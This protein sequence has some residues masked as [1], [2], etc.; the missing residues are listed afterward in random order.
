MA[1]KL[2]FEGQHDDEE[3]LFTF[4]RHPI[5]MRKGF[6]ALLIPFVLGSIPTL[7]WPDNLQNLWIAFGGLGLGFVLFLYHWMG[8]YFSIFIIT[9]QRLRQI[10]QQGF[11]NRS[12]IDIGIPKI[13]NIS[14]NIPGF[15]AATFGFGNLV[16]QTYV[17]NL[18]L[19]KIQHPTKIFNDL[20]EVLKEHGG[21]T[22]SGNYEEAIE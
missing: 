5:V 12:I 13:Q 2:Y 3:V 1:A 19:D 18:Y 4:R 7:I 22:I 9:N 10:T 6:Y 14:Y 16:V 20:L 15:T 17:G 21:N 11:F 8:W